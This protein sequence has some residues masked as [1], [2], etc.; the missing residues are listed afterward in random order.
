MASP[1]V[2]EQKE[3]PSLSLLKQVSQGER[4]ITVS[5]GLAQRGLAWAG[6]SGPRLGWPPIWIAGSKSRAST[7]RPRASI[8]D[9]GPLALR[10]APLD[11][12][13]HA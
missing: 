8:G 4:L 7:H 5:L 6:A 13:R 12:M 9:G 11:T 10:A 1:G 3:N 2:R